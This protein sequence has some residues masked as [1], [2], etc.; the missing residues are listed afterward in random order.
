MKLTD[1]QRDV[2]LSLEFFH[3]N[4]ADVGYPDRRARPMDVGG[5]DCSHHSGTLKALA[6]KGLVDRHK[7]GGR[8]GACTYALTDAG[9]EVLK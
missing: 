2:L 5:T 8:R 6:K 9:R 3:R 7:R 1:S 4:V